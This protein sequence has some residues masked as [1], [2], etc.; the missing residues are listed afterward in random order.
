MSGYFGGVAPVALCAAVAM[1]GAACGSDDA[2]PSPGRADGGPRVDAGEAPDGGADPGDPDGPTVELLAPTAPAAGDYSSGAIVVESRLTAR[3]RVTRNATT[4]EPV[5]TASITLSASA[6]GA[7][8]EAPAAP[9]GA[10]DEYAAVL[11]L[12]QLGNG[13]LAVRCTAM[14]QA[15][16]PRLGADEVST[17]LDLGPRIEIAS[18]A[19]GAS[20]GQQVDLSFV[21]TAQP[22]ADDD[23]GAA[24]ASVTATVSGAPITLTETGGGSYFATLVF[25]DPSFTPPLDGPVEVQIQAANSR[26][27]AAV[28]RR[29]AVEFVADTDGP[30]LSLE[31]PAPG[32]LVGGVI[33]ISAEV[34][35]PTGIESVFATVA[36]TYQ[37]ELL[38]T[39]GNRYAAS[40]DTRQLSTSWVFPLV[41]L[42]ARDGVGNE[43]SIG[44]VVALDNRAPLV[45]LDSPAMREAL[46]LTD[47]NC[48]TAEGL[49]CSNRFD[50]LGTDA[51]DDGETV[52]ALMELRVRAEDLTNGALAPSV[53]YVPVAGVETDAVQLFVLDD[54][55]GALLVD[56][57]GDGVCDDI[58]PA[59]VPATA[60]G[61]V[62]PASVV[63]LVPVSSAGAVFFGGDDAVY[64]GDPEMADDACQPKDPADSS[65]PA[66]LCLNSPLTRAI[67]TEYGEPALYT[68]P[69]VFSPEQCTGNAF[70]AP[71]ANIADG[72]ACV[73]AVAEDRLGNRR[74][75]PPL[76]ICVDHDGNGLDASGAPLSSIGCG[77]GLGA[78][79]DPAARPACTGACALPLT[80]A[81]LP[82]LQVRVIGTQ[83]PPDP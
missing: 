9:S 43:S 18:P 64:G 2:P 46:C 19:D 26:T 53:V 30:V 82:Y 49:I 61:G 17:Y 55:T 36:Q 12:S 21:V 14:D 77:A 56:T 52:A 44:R 63:D 66:P 15:A 70:D 38:Q 35:D 73:A 7:E 10:A 39:M 22:V 5:D 4:G 75:S 51:V 25:D 29:A 67:A 57:T 60:P 27:A 24:I 37:V 45:S 33:T 11:D 31:S 59:L 80:F 1:F 74:V 28:T 32:D 13:P 8:V 76:R 50:P 20:Y 42:T 47:G 62:T 23:T 69:P 81:D 40:F 41:E 58:N 48:E 65:P 71:A 83:A 68:I 79:A 54:D 72:W 16:A 78:I 3:C 34:S 6:G